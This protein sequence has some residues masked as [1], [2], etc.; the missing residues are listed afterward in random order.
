MKLRFLKGVIS[1]FII[2]ISVFWTYQVFANE[3]IKISAPPSIWLQ[4]K[5]DRLTGP[6]VELLE[7]I[8]DEFN[9]KITT[10]SL[11]WARAISQIKSGKL[12]MIPVI[13]YTEERSHFMEFSEPYADVPTSV[14]VPYGKTF[15]LSTLEDL[16]DKRGLTMQGDS[17][18]AEFDSY[19]SKLNILEIGGYD[20]M[21]KM[22]IGNRADYALAAKYGFIIEAKK[23]GLE[24]QMEFLPNPVKSRTLHFAFSKRSPYLKYLPEVNK[25]LNE[26][27]NTGRLEQLVNDTINKALE[28]TK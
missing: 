16:L 11:P 20:Q 24:T 14:F 25:R 17:I 22:L 15:L 1:F 9:V 7:N 27:R 21:I 3:S 13:F 28:T 5:G 26:L 23:M 2:I 6:I 19:K 18:S 8:F 12:D 4:E 10:V